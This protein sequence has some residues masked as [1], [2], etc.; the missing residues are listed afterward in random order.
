MSLLCCFF[1]VTEGMHGNDQWHAKS[2]PKALCIAT[3][4]HQ[5][6]VVAG[7]F[8]GVPAGPLWDG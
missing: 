6:G 8:D 4:D 7:G 1:G 3:S 5:K 2:T